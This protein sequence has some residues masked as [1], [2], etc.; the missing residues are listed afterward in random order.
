MPAWSVGAAAVGGLFGMLGQSSANAQNW[1]IAKEQM[2][3]Q[4]RMSNT[5]MQRRVKDLMAAGLNPMLAYQDGASSPPG[6]SATMQSTTQDLARN[7]SAL[8]LV[9]SQV[10]ANNAAADQAEWT[11]TKTAQETRSAAAAADIDEMFAKQFSGRAAEARIG[12]A[13]GRVK[14]IS[15]RVENLIKD[16][17]LKDF[18]IK[19]GKQLAIEVT[20]NLQQAGE[21]DLAEK[22]A[23]ADLWNALNRNDLGGVSKALIVLKQLL[24]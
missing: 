8:A 16:A 18:D 14:E 13:E 19:E 6:A 3:F 21:Y 10:K 17:Q 4:E 5:A 7:A 11:A 9:R 12:E 24:K 23:V 1:R 22:R 15:A 2:R 20:R